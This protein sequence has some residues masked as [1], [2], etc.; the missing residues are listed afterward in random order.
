[1]FLPRVLGTQSFWPILQGFFLL[2]LLAGLLHSVSS[3]APTP[4]SSCDRSLH[5]AGIGN[6]LRRPS[7]QML[8]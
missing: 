8:I 3:N 7:K 6:A 5:D 1:M 2:F 4:N